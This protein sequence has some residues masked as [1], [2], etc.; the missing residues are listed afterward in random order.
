MCCPLCFQSVQPLS[1]NLTLGGSIVCLALFFCFFSLSWCA[2]LHIFTSYLC[3][4]SRHCVFVGISSLSASNGSFSM[5]HNVIAGRSSH[6]LVPVFSPFLGLLYYFLRSVSSFHLSVIMR[7]FFL[8]FLPSCD[9]LGLPSLRTLRWLTLFLFIHCFVVSAAV[10]F[11]TLSLRF[12]HAIRPRSSILNFITRE[13]L[14]FFFLVVL[15]F[16]FFSFFFFISH[17]S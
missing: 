16:L 14:I 15:S 17:F 11:S 5:N 4:V 3:N 6:L 1:N 12:S 2:E 8:P 9:G 13:L 7:D 10:A